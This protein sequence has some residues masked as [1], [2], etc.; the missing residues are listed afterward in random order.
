M[1]NRQKVKANANQLSL[2]RQQMV[3]NQD[4]GQTNLHV[5]Q[6]WAALKLKLDGL[7]VIRSLEQWKK[8]CSL[9]Y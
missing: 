7:G 2:L 6:R 3:L 8:V 1:S 5:D 4:M 9:F